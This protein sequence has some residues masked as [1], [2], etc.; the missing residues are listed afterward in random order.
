M[1]IGI[2][3]ENYRSE[4]RAVG[5]RRRQRAWMACFVA[6]AVGAARCG[7]ATTCWP[8]P[9]S[10]AS[11]S[12]R[13]LGLNITTGNAGL[14]SPRPCAR[15]WA[16][17][18]TPSRGW[19][20]SGVPFFLDAAD[21]RRCVT[22]LLGVDRR[23]A[24]PARQGPVPGHRHAGRALHPDL[25]V[26]RVGIGHR[27]H[28][29]HVDPARQ[30]V[31]LRALGDRRI[32]YLIFVLCVHDGAGRTQPGAH[33]HRPRLRRGARPRHLGRDPGRPPA[34]HQAAGLRD[35]RVLRRR[36]GRAARL[37]L[38]RH[39]AGILRAAACRS[40]T[41]PRSSS[42]AWARCWAACSARSS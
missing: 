24:Q 12:S 9:A 6:G 35:R 31:R 29:G 19:R 22:A 10:S 32:F 39:H 37:L 42:A 25:P 41:S 21:R 2:F 27:R 34:A 38:R 30:S 23:P 11:T 18:A 15:S 13:T 33:A 5:R 8:W 7:A 3:H 1:R 4:E 28:A 14:I 36:G 17:A 40:S 26:P 16:S 20:G